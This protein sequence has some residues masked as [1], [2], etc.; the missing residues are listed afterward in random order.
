MVKRTGLLF[1][2][3]LN[4]S[5]CK[6]LHAHSNKI[7]IDSATRQQLLKE[8][9]NGLVDWIDEYHKEFS[10]DSDDCDAKTTLAHLYLLRNQLKKARDL[11]LEVLKGSKAMV[12]TH[13]SRIYARAALI[14]AKVYKQKRLLNANAKSEKK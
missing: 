14:L 12:G 8:A 7:S 5:K 6:F 2:A 9:E 4:L 13:K 1:R 11:L 3:K 10:F